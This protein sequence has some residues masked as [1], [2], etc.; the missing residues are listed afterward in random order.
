M[1]F[2]RFLLPLLLAGSWCAKAQYTLG[3]SVRTPQNIALDGA[4]IHIGALHGITAPDGSYEVHNIPGG[5]QRVVISYIGYKT[6]DTII[7]FHNDVRLNAILKPESLKLEEVV[8]SERQ[9]VAQ[10]SIQQQRLTT[11]TIEQYSSATL[12]DALQRLPGVYALRTGTSIVKPVINGLHSSRVPIISNNVRLEDQ[13]WGVE[14]APNLDINAAGRIS[15]IKGTNALQYGG[16][17]VGGLVLAEPMKV[18]KDTLFGKSILTLNSNG[19]GSSLATSLHKGNETGWAYNAGGSLKYMGDREAPDYVISNTGNREANF[20]GDVRYSAEK[21]SLTGYYSFYNAAIGIAKAS[22]TGSSADMAR[23][24]NSGIPGVI[25]PFTYNIG[26]PR[27]EIQH[28]LAKLEYDRKLDDATLNI[29]YAF[30]FNRRQEF[31]LRRGNFRD[32]PALD[33]TLITHSAQINWV[34]YLGAS[35]IKAGGNA[36]LQDNTASPDTGIQP[37]IPN[38]N[39]TEAGA[40]T[41]FSHSFTDNFSAEAGLRYDF[42]QITAS[43]YYQITR[44]ENLGYDGEFDNFITGERGTQYLTAPEFTYNNISAGVGARQLL[45][46]D[47]EV[48]ANAGLA[49]RNPN[50]SELFSDGLHHSN[51]TIELGDLGLERE[52]ALKLSAGFIKN[53]ETFTFEATPFVNI[54][55]NFIYLQP[56]GAETT[57]RGAFP[58]YNY[59]QANAVLTGIDI[60]STW[61]PLQNLQCDFAFAWVNG[62]NTKDDLPLVDMPPVNF[63]NTIR[64]NWQWHNLFTELRS[65]A[66]LRQERFPDYN[67]F[68]DIPQ[69]GELTPI[70]VDVSTPPAGYHLLHFRSGAQFAVGRSSMA[71]S[72]SVYNIFNTSYR[73]YLN[74]QRL[75]T[76][77]PGRNIQLQIKFNY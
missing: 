41:V 65:E 36:S 54:I 6:L 71:V 46:S 18:L 58:V 20:A 19:R 1:K 10:S 11:E 9:K 49:M 40:Y 12:G 57:I 31:D 22:H 28:H 56:T 32:V 35:V 37:L 24:I 43:K 42:A 48:V 62:N 4:H 38:Y 39:K 29:Q 55:N 33:L 13:Q 68:T 66:V 34:K 59:R 2:F 44:W 17:A 5:E 16:D 23:A 51:G 45:G 3:G 50:P 25:E 63:S 76:D 30:Q 61:K 27:Q 26:N 74:R 52:K 15:V 70:L 14:H 75:Y 8:V 7:F 64:Y 72:L 69:N 60:S 53:G 77:E 67:F 21:Y 47:Y 73:D